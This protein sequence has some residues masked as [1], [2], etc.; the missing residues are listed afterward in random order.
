MSTTHER[1]GPTRWKKSL[2]KHPDWLQRYSSRLLDDAARTDQK[3]VRWHVAQMLG[4]VKLTPRQ[5]AEAVRILR[6]YLKGSDSQIVKVSALQALAD[7]A[8]R[9]H[10][11][12]PGVLRLVRESFRIGSPSLKARAR[13]RLG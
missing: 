4:R 11:Q 2:V 12:Q 5:Q 3:E 6:D 8:V 13:K 9:D 1:E 10:A 7:L